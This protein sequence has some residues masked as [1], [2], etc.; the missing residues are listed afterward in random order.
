MLGLGDRHGVRALPFENE[1]MALAW[2]DR[3]ALQA[4]PAP[5]ALVAHEVDA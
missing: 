3:K 2:R 5:A 1:A 4:A